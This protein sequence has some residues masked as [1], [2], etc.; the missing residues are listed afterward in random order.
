MRCFLIGWVWCSPRLRNDLYCVEWDVKLYHTIPYHTDVPQFK[1]RR[2]ENT[3]SAHEEHPANDT[4][5]SSLSSVDVCKV[6]LK[7][8]LLCESKIIIY[9]ALPTALGVTHPLLVQYTISIMYSDRILRVMG[10]RG[11]FLFI[12]R[13]L[14]SQVLLLRGRFDCLPRLRMSRSSRRSCAERACML[15]L[16]ISLVRSHRSVRGFAAVVVDAIANGN[17][18]WSLRNME[19]ESRLLFWL[20]HRIKGSCRA[21]LLLQQWENGPGNVK[22]SDRIQTSSSN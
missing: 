22:T 11:R 19:V 4:T 18:R 3:L 10:G 17:W 20:T 9:A 13:A 15:P 21:R 14:S 5:T 2:L 16:L 12:F 8:V 7:L 1:Q 6:S